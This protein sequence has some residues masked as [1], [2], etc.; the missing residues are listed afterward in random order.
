METPQNSEGYQQWVAGREARKAQRKAN[1]AGQ[2]TPEV[3]LPSFQAIEGRFL[4]QRAET[5]AQVVNR[6]ADFLSNLDGLLEA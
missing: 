4:E 1:R 3:R 5:R 6:T 2:T